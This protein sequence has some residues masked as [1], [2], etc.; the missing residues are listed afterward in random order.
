[1][2]NT[3]DEHLTHET[4]KESKLQ[5]LFRIFP[6]LLIIGSFVSTIISWNEVISILFSG[7][8]MSVAG[9]V[10]SFFANKSGLKQ[11]TALGLIPVV[12]SIFWFV[13]IN[14]LSLSPHDCET[15][16]PMS[17]SVLTFIMFGLGLFII[18][19]R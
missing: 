19:K 10:Y 6:Y 14:V 8:I 13:V 5:R 11:E 12:I 4:K 3:L 17:L 16:V 15:I 7:P 9:G 18:Q 1:M 2:Q